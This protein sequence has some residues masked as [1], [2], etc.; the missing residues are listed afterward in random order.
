[1]GYG[2]VV[3]ESL[4]VAGGMM[5]VGIPAYRLPREVLQREI[6]GIIS[7]GVDLRLN[8]PVKDINAL[9]DEGYSAVFL[10]IGYEP[11][12]LG[13]EER[14]LGGVS[15]FFCRSLP[16]KEWRSA[17]GKRVVVGGVTAIDSHARRF[18]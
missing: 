15:G 13:I 8:S 17:C 14:M 3:Y 11:Q 7:E 6:E 5:R 2:V 16:S 10:A 12:R 4:P 18:V 9:F 1:M